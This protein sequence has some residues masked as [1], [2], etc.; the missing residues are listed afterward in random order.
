MLFFFRFKVYLILITQ[1]RAQG[2]RT[3]VLSWRTGWFICISRLIRKLETKWRGWKKTTRVVTFGIV[4]KWFRY[5]WFE[6]DE[7]KTNNAIGRFSMK[8]TKIRCVGK[9][10]TG[11]MMNIDIKRKKANKANERQHKNLTLAVCFCCC[12]VFR[13]V[14]FSF[15]N[16]ARA[17]VQGNIIV[18]YC[19]YLFEMPLLHLMLFLQY[20]RELGG[21]LS[22]PCVMRKKL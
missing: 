17:A 8:I 22:L 20:F 16:T 21:K 4:V 5:L 19:C 13:S 7:N 18:L 2:S 3:H 15:Q 14:L 1:E 12:F 11:D 10:I 9:K 6:I